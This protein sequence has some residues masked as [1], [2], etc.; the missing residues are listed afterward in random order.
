MK[1]LLNGVLPAAYFFALACRNRDEQ[2]PR[3][4]PHSNCLLLSA[5]L[6]RAWRNQG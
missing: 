3:E 6:R 4:F 5:C 1:P 2:T